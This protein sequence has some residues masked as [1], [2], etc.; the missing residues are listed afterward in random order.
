MFEFGRDLRRLFEKA[1]DSEDLGWLELIGVSLLETEARQQSVEAGRVSCAHPFEMSIR[2]SLLWR[3]HARRSGSASSLAKAEAEARAA[4]RHA[5][6]DEQSQ[7]AVIELAQAGLLAFDLSGGPERLA[8]AQALVAALPT[9]R[10]QASIL[11]REAFRGRL[12]ARQAILDGTPQALVEACDGL[13]RIVQSL[14]GQQGLAETELRL[15]QASLSL[16]TGLSTRDLARLD[17]AGRNLRS[18]VEGSPAD[19]RPVTRAR[20]LALC[21]LGMI[22]LSSI[23]HDDAARHQGQT[24]FDAAADQFTLDHS[25]L[26]WAAIQL[27]RADGESLPLVTLVQVEALTEDGGLILGAEAHERRLAHEI[28]Q[29]DVAGDLSTLSAIESRVKRRLRHPPV[30]ATPLDWVADQI[31]LASIALA[32][33]RW[34]GEAVKDIGL[35]LIEAAATARELGATS[36]AERARGLMP[37]PQPV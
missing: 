23:A 13:E 32:R 27:M 26:D 24:L 7:R 22:A 34:T 25:P 31:G 10:R 16:E 20:A 9:P 1:R 4:T 33:A 18:L 28:H 5:H 15:E 37:H 35:M 6:N 2:A 14:R 12:E 17:Q 8:A 29:A 21:G 19:Q 3:E 11:A 36:L 30:T